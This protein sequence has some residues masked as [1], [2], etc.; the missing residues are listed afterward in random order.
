MPLHAYKHYGPELDMEWIHPWIGLDW[1]GLNHDF[2][3]TLFIEFGH[4]AVA[5]GFSYRACH[6]DINRLNVHIVFN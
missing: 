5:P 1:I 3:E 4:M 2:Q 6:F